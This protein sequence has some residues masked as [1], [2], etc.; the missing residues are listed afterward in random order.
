[1][2]ATLL[3]AHDRI[4]SRARLNVLVHAFFYFSTLSRPSRQLLLSCTNV[5]TRRLPVTSCIPSQRARHVWISD[6]LLKETFNRF[7]HHKRYGSNVP[8]PLEAQRR[9]TKRKNTSLASP[10]PAGISI[11]PA[12]ILGS[13]SKVAWW[14]PL[15][16][17]STEPGMNYSQNSH[18][19]NGLSLMS[20]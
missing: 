4:G 16:N 11:D 14:G 17:T 9:A 20:I 13:S 2:I 18:S 12:I 5:M 6:A 19:S 15:G 3:I 10:T 7:C 8:G 1:M